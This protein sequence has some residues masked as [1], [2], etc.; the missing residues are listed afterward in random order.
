MAF[1]RRDAVYLAVAAE[2][3][4]ERLELRIGHHHADVVVERTSSPPAR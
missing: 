1:Q 4:C 3:G 2:D